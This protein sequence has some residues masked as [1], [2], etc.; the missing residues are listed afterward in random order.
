MLD[1]EAVQVGG[2]NHSHATQDLYDHISSGDYPEWTL[3]IQ[4]MDPADE[5]RYNFDPLDVTKIWPEN[6]FPLQPVGRLVLNQ[7]PGNFHLENE[8]SVGPSPQ[9]PFAFC[10]QSS[11]LLHW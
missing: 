6:L 4:T 9:K 5:H 1:D 8:M 10:G 3:A 7:N 11:S 2:S